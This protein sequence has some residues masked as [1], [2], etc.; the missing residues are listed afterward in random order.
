MSLCFLMTFWSIVTTLEEHEEH[1]HK[2]FQLL[3]DNSLYAK[4]G[5]CEF[6]KDSIQY[7]G[8]VIS[9]EG[10]AMGTSKVDDISR[11]QHLVVWKSFRSSW[12]WQVSIASM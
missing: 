10:I 12:G 4:E 2:G 9:A 5:K 11:W 3:R 8:H 7:L 1:L 6:F